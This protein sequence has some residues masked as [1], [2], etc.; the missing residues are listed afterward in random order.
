MWYSMLR[1]KHNDDNNKGNNHVSF[2]C[3]NVYNRIN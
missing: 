3:K 1:E 2:I